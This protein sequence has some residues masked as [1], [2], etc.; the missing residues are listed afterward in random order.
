[1]SGEGPL[2]GERVVVRRVHQGP[3]DVEQDRGVVRGGHPPNLGRGP[4]LERQGR[5]LP[6]RRSFGIRLRI[7]RIEPRVHPHPQTPRENPLRR[8]PRSSCPLAA[9]LTVSRCRASGPAPPPSARPPRDRS[10]RPPHRAGDSRLRR[11]SGMGPLHLGPACDDGAGPSPVDSAPALRPPPRRPT[12]CRPSPGPACVLAVATPATRWC[13]PRTSPSRPC[14]RPQR[15]AIMRQRVYPTVVDGYRDSV[16]ASSD[17][18]QRPA[19]S[20]RRGARQQRPGR[21]P[22]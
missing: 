12:R 10:W 7:V 13:S 3:V 19:R 1:M 15:C 9:T 17:R 2:P 5:G 6:G 18:R 21:T 11:Q 4:T 8:P 22:R 16:T 14:A 20:P